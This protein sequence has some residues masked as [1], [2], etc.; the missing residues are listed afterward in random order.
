MQNQ[1]SFRFIKVIFAVCYYLLIAFPIIAF[2]DDV[3]LQWDANDPVP[4]GYRLF[5]RLD[6]ETYD[7]ANPIWEGE[8]TT[9]LVQSLTVG[10]NYHFVVRAYV[11]DDESGD[12][13]EVD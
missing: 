13:N 12:S 1:K 4:N 7:Y 9:H 6:G 11:G 2:A 8:D 5:M 10:V 3:T